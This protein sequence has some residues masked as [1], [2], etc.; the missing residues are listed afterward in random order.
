MIHDTRMLVSI[1]LLRAASDLLPQSGR[2]LGPA[3][4]T[5]CG[6]DRNICTGML[7]L[8]SICH[9]RFIDLLT[10]SNWSC[11]LKLRVPGLRG[12]ALHISLIMALS[13]SEFAHTRKSK[14]HFLDP[15][16]QTNL[17]LHSSLNSITTSAQHVPP[18]SHRPGS[19]H[20]RIRG[21]PLQ[22]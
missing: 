19:R 4:E 2:A 22:L 1:K 17:C 16:I 18:T 15:L 6:C 8:L 9:D 13:L 5:A 10:F 7:L 11:L 3:Q 12:P 20:V 21:H 14:P